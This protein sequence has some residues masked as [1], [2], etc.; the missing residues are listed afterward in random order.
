VAVDFLDA[1]GLVAYG[2]ERSH[3]HLGPARLSLLCQ[4]FPDHRVGVVALG[5]WRYFLFIGEVGRA[6]GK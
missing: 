2:L 4:L 3:V 5:L 1:R 6:P